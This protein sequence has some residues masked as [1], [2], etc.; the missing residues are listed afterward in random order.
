MKEQTCCF[1]GHRTIPRTEKAQISAALRQTIIDLIE[2]GVT[3]FITGGALGFDTLAAQT[4]L[5]LKKEYPQ[6]QLSLFLPCADQANRWS[7]KAALLYE[8]IKSQA[9]D[10][11]CIRPQYEKGCMLLR[12]RCMADQSGYCVAYL[13]KNS[14]GTKYTVDYCRK[15]GV[16]VL[17]V[18]EQTQ[19]TFPDFFGNR[20][21][22]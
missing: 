13:T 17:Y 6:I 22:G 21:L 10:V 15:N 9:D 16:R 7:K 14:G 12:N 3:R 18:N 20:H 2:K 4:V 11:V 19:S 8:E 5:E 1:T